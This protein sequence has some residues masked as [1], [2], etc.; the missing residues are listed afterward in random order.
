VGIVHRDAD[1]SPPTVHRHEGELV[2]PVP[3]DR[4]VPED[5]SEQVALTS[6]IPLPRV[7]HAEHGASAQRRADGCG[8]A[9]PA[10]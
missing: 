4:L 10:T 9:A 8:E 5:F 3:N 1:S 7:H 2:P 6:P